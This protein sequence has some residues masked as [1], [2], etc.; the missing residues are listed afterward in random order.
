MQY[1][2]DTHSSRPDG[3]M[4]NNEQECLFGTRPLGTINLLL[5][6]IVSA[7][8]YK[9]R[10]LTSSRMLWLYSRRCQQPTEKSAAVWPAKSIK[11]NQLSYRASTG[12]RK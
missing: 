8:D 7:F 12:R 11:F 2:S 1:A 4:L 10:L 6:N 5:G 3:T 9:L